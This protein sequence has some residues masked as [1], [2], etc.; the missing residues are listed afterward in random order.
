MLHLVS[1]G[2]RDVAAKPLNFAEF[3]PALPSLTHSLA[4][5]VHLVNATAVSQ[6]WEG[7]HCNT[8]NVP[9]VWYLS[10]PSSTNTFME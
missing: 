2:A 10:A 7:C 6:K 5:R 9:L 3:S 4:Q 8:C 1:Y